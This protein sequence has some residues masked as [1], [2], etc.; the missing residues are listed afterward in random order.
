LEAGV[1]QADVRFA[2][3][4]VVLGIDVRHTEVVVVGV[5]DLGGGGFARGTWEL[6]NLTVFS[7]GHLV[8][9]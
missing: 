8:P 5:E 2:R 7:R 3:V 4:E 6:R 9:A 1:G